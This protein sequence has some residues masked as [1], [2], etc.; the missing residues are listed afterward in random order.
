MEV[1]QASCKQ[2]LLKKNLTKLK[3]LQVFLSIDIIMKE[4]K[5]NFIFTI[6]VN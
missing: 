3:Y 5:Y 4:Y 1:D 6:N 2:E